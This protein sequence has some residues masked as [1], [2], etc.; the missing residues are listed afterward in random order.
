MTTDQDLGPRKKG[1]E[2][3]PSGVEDKVLLDLANA[4]TALGNHLGL[5]TRIRERTGQLD[6][7][8]LDKVLE[9]SRAQHE[10]AS[11]HCANCGTSSRNSYAA[12]D[13]RELKR[14]A[15]SRVRM[16]NVARGAPALSASPPS[17]ATTSVEA[18]THAVFNHR[19]VLGVILI[20][21]L[22][23]FPTQIGVKQLRCRRDSRGLWP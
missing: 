23:L 17:E 4:L 21:H 6:T 3:S 10:R 5:A 20:H 22:D 18:D 1:S 14:D 7:E 11:G 16:K 12:I 8:N 19:F 13:L 15:S 2:R 9:K